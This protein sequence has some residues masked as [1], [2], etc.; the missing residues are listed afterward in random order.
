[1]KRVHFVAFLLLCNGLEQWTHTERPLY[2][3]IPSFSTPTAAGSFADY[4]RKSHTSYY[5]MGVKACGSHKTN[6]YL[7]LF[8]YIFFFFSSSQSQTSIQHHCIM[9][10]RHIYLCTLHLSCCLVVFSA[11]TTHTP[12]DHFHVIDASISL[13]L[14]LFIFL[15]YYI[16]NN[17]FM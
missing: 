1:M 12:M 10:I 8:M 17:K 3:R 16:N 15:T 11:L 7:L 9:H 2:F 5:V 13:F 6:I 4:I 14:L